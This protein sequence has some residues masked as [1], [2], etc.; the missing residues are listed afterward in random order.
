MQA[1]AVLDAHALFAQARLADQPVVQG[2]RL[3]NDKAKAKC[4]EATN[5]NANRREPVKSIL[6]CQ[7]SKSVHT[8]SLQKEYAPAASIVTINS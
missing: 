2:A 8:W 1:V 6:S 4:E 7:I 5:I 3:P